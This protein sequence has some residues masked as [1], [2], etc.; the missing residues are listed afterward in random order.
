[1]KAF[2]KLEEIDGRE[3]PSDQKILS[4]VLLIHMLCFYKLIFKRT[5]AS[6]LINLENHFSCFKHLTFIKVKNF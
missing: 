1:M 3:N 6:V 4:C 2:L 5:F